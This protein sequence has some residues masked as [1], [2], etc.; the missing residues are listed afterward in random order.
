MPS[1]RKTSTGMATSGRVHLSI[2]PLNNSEN[3]LI[4]EFI[5]CHY[6]VEKWLKYLEKGQL[7]AD[8]PP[9]MNKLRLR[10]KIFELIKETLAF[11]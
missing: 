9:K 4:L 6:E 11:D 7:D 1:V 2:F 3:A 5:L 10:K 8:I